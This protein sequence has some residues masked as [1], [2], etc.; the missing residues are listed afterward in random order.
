VL[1]VDLLVSFDIVSWNYGLGRLGVHSSFVAMDSDAEKNTFRPNS[2]NSHKSG[3]VYTIRFNFLQR[4][5]MSS[6]I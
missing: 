1:L 5:D 6:T 3:P 4:L 2:V